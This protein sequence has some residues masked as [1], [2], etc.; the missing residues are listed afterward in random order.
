MVIKLH[1]YWTDEPIERL[2]IAGGSELGHLYSDDGNVEE[3]HQAAEALGLKRSWFQPLEDMPHY[4]LWRSPL[5]RA[6][7]RHEIVDDDEFYQ[8]MERRR[9]S[10]CRFY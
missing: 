2:R 9:I 8:D 1:L 5:D 6:K 4:D 3:L 7:E 10:L